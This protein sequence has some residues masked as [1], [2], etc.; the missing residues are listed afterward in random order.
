MQCQAL[1]WLFLNIP[2]YNYEWKNLYHL[3]SLFNLTFLF[4]HFVFK[5]DCHS[6]LHRFI[7]HGKRCISQHSLCSYFVAYQQ[8]EKSSKEFFFKLL[9]IQGYF[10]DLISC[11]SNIHL[12]NLI[13]ESERVALFPVDVMIYCFKTPPLTSSNWPSIL[14][15]FPPAFDKPSFFLI[16]FSLIMHSEVIWVS[17]FNCWLSKKMLLRVNW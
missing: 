5:N 6:V 14:G 11:Y 4:P 13:S 10:N 2:L 17:N 16:P 7:C 1:C 3:D 9:V 12:E 8:A 15:R